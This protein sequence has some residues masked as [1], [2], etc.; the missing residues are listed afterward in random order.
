[1]RRIILAALPLFVLCQLATASD[2][3]WYEEGFKRNAEGGP[4]AALMRDSSFPVVRN[5]YICGAVSNAKYKLLEHYVQ[6]NEQNYCYQDEDCAI[7][8]LGGFCP[9]AAHRSQLEGYKLFTKSTAYGEL[10][11][12]WTANRCMG[13]VGLCLPVN[14]AKCEIPEGK[15]VG[16]CV[17]KWGKEPRPVRGFMVAPPKKD[18]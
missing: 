11:K 8:S 13:P 17:G 2:K 3:K 5:Q 14:E 7:G 12:E 9:V 4:A 18:E 6:P 10:Q 1:M 16:K 15:H